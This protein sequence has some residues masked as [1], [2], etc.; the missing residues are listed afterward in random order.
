MAD[1]EGDD[2]GL[3]ILTLLH[4]SFMNSAVSGHIARELT[5]I[6]PVSQSKIIYRK[7]LTEKIIWSKDKKVKYRRSAPHFVRDRRANIL[8]GKY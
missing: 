5:I 2:E 7:V 3:S 8:C 6:E 1:D 4:N